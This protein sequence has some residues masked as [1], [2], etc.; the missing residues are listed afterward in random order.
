MH[1]KSIRNINI[2]VIT[3]IRRNIKAKVTFPAF[4]AADDTLS[5]SQAG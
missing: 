4:S 5:V 1:G 2:T 3:I